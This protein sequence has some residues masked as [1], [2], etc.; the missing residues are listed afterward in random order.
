MKDL[1]ELKI[2]ELENLSIG[3]ENL[4]ISELENLKID[5]KKQK[6]DLESN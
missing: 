6:N 2:S 1:E 4:G 3:L 5:D